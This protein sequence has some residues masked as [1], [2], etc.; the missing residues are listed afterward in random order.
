MHATCIAC[1]PTIV[2]Y[3]QGC[4]GASRCRVCVSV[5]GIVG[6][7]PVWRCQPWRTPSQ[8]AAFPCA[9]ITVRQLTHHVLPPS[10]KDSVSIDMQTN[11]GGTEILLPFC[12]SDF[13]MP[14]RGYFK[15]SSTRP[16]PRRRTTACRPRMS[17][18]AVQ[19]PIGSSTKARPPSWDPMDN[20]RLY[21][22]T[23]YIRLDLG[24]NSDVSGCNAST[25]VR[26]G[27]LS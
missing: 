26:D 16:W 19:C 27:T 3:L 11:I 10:G 24:C 15:N 14:C 13:A 4:A 12:S 6:D 2:W 1:L 25:D 21:V 9:P 8:S 22:C 18:G 7:A 17:C 23:Q 5:S 20:L